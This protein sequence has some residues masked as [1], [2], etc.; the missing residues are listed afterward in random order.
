MNAFF[1]IND[2]LITAPTSD[3]ILDGVTRKSV[4]DLAKHH[5]IPVEV[6]KV[7]VTEIV[8][9]AKDGSLKEIFGAGTAVVISPVKSFSYQGIDYPVH[10][11]EDTYSA[12][13]KK[14]ITDIQYNRAEDPFGWR[15]RVNA[16]NY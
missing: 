9:A 3:R 13:F 1:R 8:A 16:S 7:P 14:L 12:L 2:T 5:N 4:I 6:R 11:P 15:Y 10:Q